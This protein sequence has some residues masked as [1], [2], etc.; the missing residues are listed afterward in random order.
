MRFFELLGF[1]H[2]MLYLVPTLI[3]IIVFG[4]GL[5][6]THFQ[7]KN[8]EARKQKIHRRYPV[9]RRHRVGLRRSDYGYQA[10]DYRIPGYRPG[11]GDVVLQPLRQGAYLRPGKLQEG[12]SGIHPQRPENHI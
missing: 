2:I 4:T 11:K 9:E 5:G 1:Q 3:F 12:V 7:S 6:F 8:S 10:T